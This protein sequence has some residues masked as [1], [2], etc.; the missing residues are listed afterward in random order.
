MYENRNNSTVFEKLL[1]TVCDC[2][3]FTDTVM[4]IFMIYIKICTYL[5]EK[6]LICV[7]DFIA[8]R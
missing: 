3:N 4:I 6:L 5:S 7:I 8:A 2:V 1:L